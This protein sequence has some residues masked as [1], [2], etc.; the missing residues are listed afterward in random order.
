MASSSFTQRGGIGGRAGSFLAAAFLILSASTLSLSADAAESA[1]AW[2]AGLKNLTP[3]QG[4]TLLRLARDLFPQEQLADSK[5]TACIDPYDAAASD[6]QTK[7]AIE[8]SIGMAEGAARRMGYKTYT[9]ISDDEERERMA[10]ML[11][12]GRWMRQFKKSLETC[13]KAEAK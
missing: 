2:A 9:G 6:P 12:E 5:F 10:K 13:L 4:E 8:D 7:Q 1:S 3:E 11:A